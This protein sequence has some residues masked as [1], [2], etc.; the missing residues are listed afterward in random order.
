MP[1]TVAAALAPAP[2]PTTG[3]R[4]LAEAFGANV[5]PASVRP[6]RSIR[7][8][9]KPFARRMPTP[10][11]SWKPRLL[12]SFRRKASRANAGSRARGGSGAAGAGG[13]KACRREARRRRGARTCHAACRHP[14][15][16][17]RRWPLRREDDGEVGQAPARCPQGRTEASGPAD[18]ARRCALG[19]DRHSVTQNTRGTVKPSFAYNLVR[20]APRTVYTAGFSSGAA[21]TEGNGFSARRS[22]SCRLARFDQD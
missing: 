1:A 17:N 7:C 20:T 6:A 5:V 2:R 21:Q 14:R 19:F 18:R 11:P 15:A 22:R 9:T 4:A 16:S 3:E 8:W 12:P 10:T 13:R